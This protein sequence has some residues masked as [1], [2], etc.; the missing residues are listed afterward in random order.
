MESILTDLSKLPV[1][2]IYVQNTTTTTTTTTILQP[3]GL[4]LELPG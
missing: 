1:H 3:A 4:F 2:A